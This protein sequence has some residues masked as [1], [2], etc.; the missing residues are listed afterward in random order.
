M[1]LLIY[2]IKSILISGLLSGYYALFL[3]NRLCH[4]F[5]RYFILGIPVFSFLIPALSFKL[6]LFWKELAAGSP[7]RLM[8]VG[9]GKLEEAVIA[10]GNQGEGTGLSWDR[11][12]IICS[13]LVTVVLSI[14]LYKT[15][16]YIH[17]L[18]RDKPFLNLPEAT[19]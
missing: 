9:Q 6:P 7:M 12:M 5:N 8:E 2:I 11:I 4:R 15:I 10:Y 16:R 13:L 18:C 19:V 17:S 14:R 1:T 3:K